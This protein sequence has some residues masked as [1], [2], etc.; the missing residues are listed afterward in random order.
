MKRTAGILAVAAFL[1]AS[2]G[3]PASAASLATPSS[4]FNIYCILFPK[5]CQ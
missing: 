4:G 1:L 5:K 3:P 2:V